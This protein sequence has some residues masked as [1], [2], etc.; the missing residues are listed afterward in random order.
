MAENSLEANGNPQDGKAENVEIEALRKINE[1]IGEM[2]V[3]LKMGNS[4]EVN[5]SVQKSGAEDNFDYSILSN[6][7]SRMGYVAAK[8]TAG[9]PLQALHAFGDDLQHKEQLIAKAGGGL[10]FGAAMRTALA[11]SGTGRAIVGSVLGFYMVKDAM[12]PVYEGLKQ[13]YNAESRAEL[14]H[15]VNTFS[16]GLGHFC[17]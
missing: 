14:E 13:G 16:G 3:Q 9:V 5:I 4:G 6:P 2:P 1:D 10:A 7:V 8:G 15:G 12:V 17:L 11:K